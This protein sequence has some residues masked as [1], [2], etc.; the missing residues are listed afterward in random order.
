MTEP[1]LLI[2]DIGGTNARF[3]LAHADKP[4]FSNELT[5][6]CADYETA[7]QGIEDYLQRSVGAVPQIIC[8]AAAGPVIDDRIILSNNSWVIDS[9]SLQQK[10]ASARV[11]LLNDFEAIAHSIPLLGDNDTATIGLVPPELEGKDR[12]TLGVL[13]PGTGLGTGGLIGRGGG[14]FPV[15]GEG[16]H[17][18]FAPETRTQLEVLKQL[19]H[20]YERVTDER[21]VS[22]PGLEN[23]YW[24]LNKVH[25]NPEVSIQAA[26]IFS[27]VLAQEDVVATEAAQIFFEVLGQIAGNLALTL[28]AFDG[29]YLAGGILKRYPDL[30]KASSFRAGFENKGRHRGLMER[31]PTLLIL[32]PQPGLLGASYCARKLLAESTF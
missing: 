19:R 15:V 24:A 2:G 17:A 8:I 22:G 30:L 28:G 3:A 1:C 18:G 12:F 20:R 23:I 5:L 29:I 13:G 14:V 7:E 9:T 11:S 26:E 6:A 31:V 32:H 21:L 10:F 27:R 4:G 16:S 25:G